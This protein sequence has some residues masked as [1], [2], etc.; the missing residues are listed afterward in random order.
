MQDSSAELL[1]F[2]LE[3]SDELL[4]ALLL[5]APVCMQLHWCNRIHV[6]ERRWH[7]HIIFHLKGDFSP[8][9]DC[10]THIFTLKRY[11]LFNCSNVQRRILLL[12]LNLRWIQYTYMY[13]Y[14]YII[15]WTYMIVPLWFRHWEM[16]QNRRLAVRFIAA[17]KS[18]IKIECALFTWTSSK[19]CFSAAVAMETS[20]KSIN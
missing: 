7:P 15:Y 13:I 6:G 20:L 8:I 12:F 19:A 2:Y 14:T 11:I 1:P 9:F 16:R 17:L 3:S 10:L 5:L 18:S 4:S